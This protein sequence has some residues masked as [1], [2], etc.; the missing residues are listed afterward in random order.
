MLFLQE[1]S[2][3]HPARMVPE[4]YGQWRPISSNATPEGRVPN[5]RVEMIISG[6]DLNAEELNEA[7]QNYIS[8]SNEGLGVTGDPV[9]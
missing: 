4:S 7:I 6:V 5:R 9:Q 2:R 8:Q 3:I 1:N